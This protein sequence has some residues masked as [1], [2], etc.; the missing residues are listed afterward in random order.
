MKVKSKLKLYVENC[1]NKINRLCRKAL[2]IP[3][4]A[5]ILLYHEHGSEFIKSCFPEYT[6]DVLQIDK[7]KYWAGVA[8]AAYLY[9]VIKNT[10]VKRAYI[11]IAIKLIKPKLII[12]FIDN[13]QAFYSIKRDNPRVITAFIQNGWRG[14]REDV[15]EH[16]KPAPEQ[17]VDYM[18]VFNKNIG[19]HYRK[20]IQGNSIVVGCIRNNEIPLQ[21]IARD[22]SIGFISPFRDYTSKPLFCDSQG[23]E[24]F[25]DDYYKQDQ[26]IV[27]NIAQW[28]KQNNVRLKIITSRMDGENS[29]EI[30]FYNKI[31]KPAMPGLFEIAIRTSVSSSYYEAEKCSLVVSS[32]STLGYELFARG[33][34]VAFLT[35]RGKWIHD[36]DRNFG[37]PGTFPSRGSFWCDNADAGAINEILSELWH[38]SPRKW[39]EI[40]AP[41]KQEVLEY[42]PDN[43]EFKSYLTLLRDALH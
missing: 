35:G 20:Y 1:S 39:Q 19:N 13:D 32:V 43:Y 9:S 41:F 33:N 29:Q 34:K 40:A 36:L 31:L 27:R 2:C 22:S 4:S 18:F 30:R 16:L 23:K 28:C 15:F 5:E 25:W 6:V 8:I 11:N 38:I 17:N 14:I 7:T 10:A 24:I 12:T 21:K 26:I 3:N 42:Y 37:W